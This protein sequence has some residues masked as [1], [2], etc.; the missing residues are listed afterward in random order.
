MGLLG[1]RIISCG[2]AADGPRSNARQRQLGLDLGLQQLAQ[3]KGGGPHV[4]RGGEEPVEAA[5]AIVDVIIELLEIVSLRIAP[6]QAPPCR[7]VGR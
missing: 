3:A 7:H 2:V 6:W 5:S 4:T 1:N